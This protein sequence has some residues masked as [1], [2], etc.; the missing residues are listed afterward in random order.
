MKN[1]PL[2][3]KSIFSFLAITFAITY[4]IEGGLILAG[5]RL[6]GLTASFG[7]VV[8][9]GVMWVPTLATVLTVKF[10]TRE[11]FAGLNSRFGSWKPYLTSGL[12]VPLCLPRRPGRAQRL[13]QDAVRSR[14]PQT[15]ADRRLRR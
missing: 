2:D 8:I 9:A 7:Q 15:R 13:C 14:L 11:G 12:L 1:T 10:I 5:F 6:T 4:A 3:R